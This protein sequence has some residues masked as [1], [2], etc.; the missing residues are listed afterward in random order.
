MPSVGA[1][2]DS[3][4]REWKTTHW[5]EPG[6]TQ[7]PRNAIFVAEHPVLSVVAKSPMRSL[8]TESILICRILISKL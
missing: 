2:Q 5:S 8:T 6:I 3:P 4:V 7:V 1:R